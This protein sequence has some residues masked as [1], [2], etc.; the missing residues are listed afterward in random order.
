MAYA[1]TSKGQVTIPKRIRDML[2]LEPGARVEFERSDD[3]RIVIK[4][5]APSEPNRFEK[6]RGHAGPGMTTDELLR[7]TRG[8]APGDDL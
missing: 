7:L 3:G 6:L 2:G 5:A 8:R 1:V 4:R